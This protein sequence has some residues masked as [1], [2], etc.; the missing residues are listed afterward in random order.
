MV[1]KWIVIMEKLQKTT[2]IDDKKPLNLWLDFLSADRSCQ[3]H[4]CTLRTTA[5][6]RDHTRLVKIKHFIIKICSLI[7]MLLPVGQMPSDKSVLMKTIVQLLWLHLPHLLSVL[8]FLLFRSKPSILFLKM[9]WDE[10]RI[11]YL[12][13]TNWVLFNSIQLDFYSCS[14]TDRHS[15]GAWQKPRAWSPWNK[16]QWLSGAMVDRSRRGE[17]PGGRTEG[18]KDQTHKSYMQK[19]EATWKCWHHCRY[20][21]CTHTL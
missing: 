21:E 11:F 8:C 19:H 17:T 5:K 6:G 12:C 3:N 20:Q 1:L 4:F 7:L 10:M 14:K 9:W 15:P 2:S 18:G 13:I 16:Q